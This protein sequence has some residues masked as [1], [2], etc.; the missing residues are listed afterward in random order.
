MYV[1][2]KHG[3]DGSVKE[4][5]PSHDLWT[6]IRRR[7]RRERIQRAFA[8]YDETRPDG[9][10][11]FTDDRTEYAGRIFDQ[12]PTADI[13]NLHWIRGFVDLQ[14]FFE[15]VSVPVVWTLHDM[16]A[17]TGGCHYNVGCEKYTAACGACP[18][19][20]SDNE[21]D[22]SRNIW[23]RK[24]EAFSRVDPEQLHIVC[25]SKWLAKKA[26]SSTLLE[27]FPVTVIPYGLDTDRFAPRPQEAVRTALSL[28]HDRP[29]VLFVADTAT[30]QRK[31]FDLLSDALSDLKDPLLLSVGSGKPSL[32]NSGRHIHLGRLSSDRL[33]SAVYSAA[34]VF[35]IPS[36]QDNLPNTVLESMACGTPVVGFNAGGIPDMVRPNETGWLAEVGSVRSLRQTLDTAL[37][38]DEAR[39]RMSQRCRDVVETEYIIDVQAQRYCNL[40]RCIL[41]GSSESS[42]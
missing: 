3:D 19:L 36:L 8:R 42:D 28:P 22:L 17:F 13:I 11:P 20:E 41:N 32:D 15:R 26:R 40:Y 18:Q 12:M 10:E 31:G 14:A 16:N 6:R 4:F 35:V 29:V 24:K 37:S 38:D 39:Q 34:D 21:T 2:S 33:L 27:S 9:L 30:R 7:W 25:P 1:R 5:Q 23:E